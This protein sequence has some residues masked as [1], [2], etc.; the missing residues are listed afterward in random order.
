MTLNFK[1]ASIGLGTIIV[2]AGILFG[3]GK[4]VGTTNINI[5][6]VEEKIDHVAIDVKSID[7]KIN[8]LIVD[9]LQDSTKAIAK[10]DTDTN[11]GEN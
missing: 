3:A 2:I 11:T 5:I 10:K 7:E 9:K 6:R 8:I 4:F 1:N